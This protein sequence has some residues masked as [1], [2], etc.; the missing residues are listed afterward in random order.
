MPSYKAEPQNELLTGSVILFR[1]RVDTYINTVNKA[2][3][4]IPIDKVND[5]FSHRIITNYNF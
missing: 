4:T 1:V 2:V 3:T 5:H